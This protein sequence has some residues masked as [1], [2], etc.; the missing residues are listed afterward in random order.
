VSIIRE[1]FVLLGLKTDE[2]SFKKA[3][4]A[5]Q[6]LISAG[7]TL[8]LTYGAV[9]LGGIVTDAATAGDRFAKMA[10][11][12]GE[13]AE[14][15]Q[16]LA[17]AA[18]RSGLKLEAM[19]VGLGKLSK[20]ALDSTTGNKVAAETFARLGISVRGN[21]GA[22]K[23]SSAL[24][25]EVADRIAGI[26]DPTKRTALAMQVFGE[27]GAQMIPFLEGGG[28][29]IRDLRQR[30]RE[31]GHVIDNEAAT[32]SEGLVDSLTDMNLATRG[33]VQRLGVALIPALQRLADSTTNA[34]IRHRALID[35][36]LNA[37]AKAVDFATR[38]FTQY[39]D[40][41]EGVAAN[42]SVLKV[43]LSA[44]A[45][46]AGGFMLA[47]LGAAAMAVWS[48]VTAFNAA[49]AAALLAQVKALA[50]PIAVGAA[51]AALVL[52][53]DDFITALQ[54]GKS[55]IGDFIAEFLERPNPDDNVWVEILR[56][57]AS[58]LQGALEST[59]ALIDLFSSS[60]ADNIKAQQYWIHFWDPVFDHW[61]KQSK[62]IPILGQLVK[63]AA[64]IGRGELGDDIA[65]RQ[66]VAAEER[67]N[68]PMMGIQSEDPASR[69]LRA[70]QQRVRQGSERARADQMRRNAAAGIVASPIDP[71]VGTSPESR[72]VAPAVSPMRSVSMAPV[73]Q[74]SID[75][76]GMDPGQV[77]EAVRAGTEAA[78][79]STLVEAQREFE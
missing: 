55:V 14:G 54:G 56:F 1:L 49:G 2:A 40:I 41:L 21:D 75:A 36:G 16:E 22:L 74:Q 51:I 60:N 50:L 5:V 62:D 31:L 38:K 53:V 19:R 65:G 76:R 66:I 32:A 34:L 13:T 4:V 10:R 35:R 33:I 6:G 79:R 25:E 61:E 57:I 39:S 69:R 67:V 72:F 70:E 7:R 59:R 42:A 58:G 73:I 46:V 8:V 37:I 18:D 64:Y 20:T 63:A 77:Q 45:V 52:I 24:M 26:E 23:A 30:A 15:F 9:K 27:S 12:V 68:N 78:L 43:A 29:G 71:S 11:Q 47:K 44:L 17:F 3:D 28:Q 48:L